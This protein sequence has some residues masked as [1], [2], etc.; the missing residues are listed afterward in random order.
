M[1][2]LK[3]HLSIPESLNN[4][5]EGFSAVS[6]SKSSDKYVIS[7][8][9]LSGRIVIRSS[10]LDIMSGVLFVESQMIL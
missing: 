7:S 9:V 2:T 8:E 10:F 6:W 5:R 3:F 4:N 1:L